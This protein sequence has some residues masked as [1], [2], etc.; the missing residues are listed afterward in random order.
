MYSI[1]ARIILLVFL[2]HC[3]NFL[4]FGQKN[5]QNSK[6]LLEEFVPQKKVDYSFFVSNR[7]SEEGS[8][9]VFKIR[10]GLPPISTVIIRGNFIFSEN[11]DQKKAK[12]TIYNTS[13]DVRIGIFNTNAQTGKYLIILAPNIKYRFEV[14]IQG[15][16]KMEYIVEVPLKID[17]EVCKQEIKVKEND[18]GK[19]ELN[20]KNWFVEENKNIFILT[21]YND[22][23]EQNLSNYLTDDVKE[24]EQL[25]VDKSKNQ[26]SFS[27]ID[28][29]VKKQIEE[30]KKKPKK[31]KMFFDNKDFKNARI[32]YEQLIM[33]DSE[34][35]FMN[36]HYGICLFHTE[37]NKSKSI[38]SLEIAALLNNRYIRLGRIFYLNV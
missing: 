16:E 3:F 32:L 4:G 7:D 14:E 2:T 1:V 17:Y 33:L 37:K 25:K 15:L 6:S 30:E 12:I 34:D 5:E 38:K 29:L 36:Y 31:A 9:N 26:K 20:I 27:N 28:E 10:S 8:Y 21:T 19:L 11:P 18:S 35:S 24:V 13:T 23:T 22:S